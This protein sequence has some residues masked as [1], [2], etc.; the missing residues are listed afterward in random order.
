MKKNN[1]KLEKTRKIKKIYFIKERLMVVSSDEFELK[2]PELSRAKL[3]HLN[4]RA[5]TKLTLCTSIRCKFLPHRK[6]SY[7]VLLLWLKAI[8]INS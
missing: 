6:F 3:G 4:F 7:F 2:F 8:V 1:S 5:E